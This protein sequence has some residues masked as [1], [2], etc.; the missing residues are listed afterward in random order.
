L[1][2]A[3]FD[4]Q[5]FE[6]NVAREVMLQMAHGDIDRRTAMQMLQV[7][8]VRL[9]GDSARIPEMATYDMDKL[10]KQLDA[11]AK[12]AAGKQL[13]SAI[14][15]GLT[16][17]SVKPFD[18]AENVADRELE[19]WF[20]QQYHS[21]RDV[22]E[23]SPYG[24]PSKGQDRYPMSDLAA[25]RVGE[26]AVSDPNKMLP[27]ASQSTTDYLAKADEISKALE[28]AGNAEATRIAPDATKTGEFYQAHLNGALKA[29]AH[30]MDP[31][32]LAQWIADNTEKDKDGKT[33]YKSGVDVG[34]LTKFVTDYINKKDFPSAFDTPAKPDETM[35][36]LV[37]TGERATIGGQAEAAQRGYD[38]VSRYGNENPQLDFEK[39]TNDLLYMGNHLNGG[40]NFP[41]NG[42][43]RTAVN[44]YYDDKAKFDQQKQDW[45]VEQ[46]MNLGYSKDQALKQWTDY[47]NRFKTPE[48]IAA[49]D[50]ITATSDAITKGWDDYH[51]CNKNQACED[52]VMKGNPALLKAYVDKYGQYRWGGGGSKEFAAATDWVSKN[53]PEYNDLWTQY[54]KLPKGAKRKAFADANPVL[55]FLNFAAYNNDEYKAALD[56]G[57]TDDDFLSWVNVPDN[58]DDKPDYYDKNPRAFLVNAWMYGRSVNF[59]AG[60]KPEDYGDYGK[61]YQ[62]AI[63]NWGEGIWDLVAQYKRGWDKRQ[64]AAFF[65]NNPKYEEWYNWWYGDQKDRGYSASYARRTGPGYDSLGHRAYGSWGGGG[66]GYSGGANTGASKGFP[67]F[68][69][70]FPDFYS[71]SSPTWLYPGE[72]RR[73]QARSINQEWGSTPFKPT[74][75]R[76]QYV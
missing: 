74:Q 5:F 32:L 65:D 21:N 61:D 27:G 53:H 18:P 4:P 55:K 71:A 16:S 54:Y 31:T 8:A 66:G 46:L 48:E 64:K 67:K 39:R 12:S 22:N 75:L 44:K 45:V 25:V 7:L 59:E 19:N 73:Y 29:A 63:D 35:K 13:T 26:Y 70:R 62:T 3:A 17:V 40:P 10:N 24:F 52:K 51:A 57:F 11:A 6:H 28:D 1:P 68:M 38:L 30:Y 49:T 76:N 43:D 9:R 50:K 15:G 2:S 36:R 34:D 42:N 60:K 20:A 58:K 56:Q 41:A 69:V 14:T 33:R 37:G 23:G 47:R 72:P